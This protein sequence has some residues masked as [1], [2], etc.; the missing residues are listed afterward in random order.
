LTKQETSDKA[1][2]IMKAVLAILSKAGY[3]NTTISEIE[4]RLASAGD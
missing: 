2:V 1:A 4:K 3:E